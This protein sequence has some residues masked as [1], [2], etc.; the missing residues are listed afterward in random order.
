MHVSI[1]ANV[2]FS[3]GRAVGGGLTARFGRKAPQREGTLLQGL[4]LV[5]ASD[6]AASGQCC[7]CSGGGVGWGG[8]ADKRGVWGVQG[9]GRGVGDGS[10]ADA[11]LRVG[12]GGHADAARA[13][14]PP[15]ASAGPRPAAR[16]LGLPYV[17]WCGARECG[18]QAARAA[19]RVF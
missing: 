3:A 18:A 11:E 17:V 2:I 1:R 12:R 8:G 13:C 7:G 4:K 19:S 16:A 6:A 10:G 14:P 9:Q 5:Q 15:P